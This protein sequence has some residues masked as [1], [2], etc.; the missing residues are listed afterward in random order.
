MKEMTLD[1][2]IDW[3]VEDVL[4]E[5][6]EKS[7]LNLLHDIEYRPVDAEKKML[8]QI[9]TWVVSAKEQTGKEVILEDHKKTSVT[10]M[11]KLKEALT[12]QLAA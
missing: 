2:F 5:P 8:G 4:G 6:D 11:Y 7:K 10:I 3:V 1:E 12:S 9:C